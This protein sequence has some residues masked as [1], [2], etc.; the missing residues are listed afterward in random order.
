MEQVVCKA[1]GKINL[2][3]DVLGKRADGYHEVSMVMHSVELHDIV[4]IKRLENREFL[5]TTNSGAI[6]PGRGNIAYRAAELMCHAF[7][8]DSGFHID[9]QKNIPVAGG[10]A[11]GSADAAAVLRGIN[12]LCALGIPLKTLMDLGLRLG[13]DIPFCI[14][15]RPALAEGIGE[16]LTNI[17]GLPECDIVLVNPGV[18][19]STKEIYEAVDREEKLGS[20]NNEEL[21]KCL[22]KRDIY[23]A[24]RC[25]RNLMQQVTVKKCPE[26]VSILETLYDLG[27]VH[28]MMSGSGPTCFGIF[29]RGAVP[30]GIEKSFPGWFVQCTAPYCG[31]E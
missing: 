25:M 16:K 27:A 10:M 24:S 23:G 14:Q 29:E 17:T 7:S 6:P 31:S 26:I 11:G 28:A 21:I 12:Q 20:V 22:R 5:L 19:I 8:I 3:L 4:T 2:S 1:R 30:D 13:A 18:D 9:I 15:E